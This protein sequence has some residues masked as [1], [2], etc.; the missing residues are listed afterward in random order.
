[1][2]NKYVIDRKKADTLTVLSAFMLQYKT[3]SSLLFA[4]RCLLLCI[5]TV[6]NRSGAR[7]AVPRTCS[8]Y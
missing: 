4:K 3:C 5:L 2:H 1:M 8:V 7:F 6:C